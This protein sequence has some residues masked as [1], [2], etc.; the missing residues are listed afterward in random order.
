MAGAVTYPRTVGREEN[1]RIA[2]QL[3]KELNKLDRLLDAAGSIE[4]ILALVHRIGWNNL[5]PDLKRRALNALHGYRSKIS[6]HLAEQSTQYQDWQAQ[7]AELDKNDVQNSPNQAQYEYLIQSIN[8]Y[9]EFTQHVAAFYPAVQ[10]ATL[11]AQDVLSPAP[12]H[13]QLNA[14]PYYDFKALDQIEGEK[15]YEQY[16]QE[17]NGEILCQQYLHKAA[18][19]GQVSIPDVV[20]NLSRLNANTQEEIIAGLEQGRVHFLQGEFPELADFNLC[21]EVLNQSKIAIGTYKELGLN[22]HSDF[23]QAQYQREHMPPYSCFYKDNRDTDTYQSRRDQPINEHC[24]VY[25][26][27]KALCFFVHDGQTK[28]TEHRMV[29]DGAKAFAQSLHDRGEHATTRQWLDAAVEWNTKMLMHRLK[30]DKDHQKHS[31]RDLAAQAKKTAIALRN[32]TQAHM[33][34]L[35]VDMDTKLANSIVPNGGVYQVTNNRKKAA[36]SD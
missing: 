34:A 15:S 32:V 9:R 35:G 21:I 19:L 8:D 28:G 16:Y 31:A 11:R 33:L 10:L 23:K 17:A 24:G 14:T 30:Y 5:P 6:K 4:A 13:E 12:Y 1:K 27:D 22:R 26:E 25:S 7:L 20:D 29:S 36:N 18:P 2:R 3:I